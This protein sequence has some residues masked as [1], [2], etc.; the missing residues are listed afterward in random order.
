M[1]RHLLILTI[2]ATAGLQAW[3]TLYNNFAVDVVGISGLQTGIVQSL[4]EVPGFLSLLVVYLLLIFKEH[5]LSAVS[6]ILLGAGVALTGFLPSFSGLILTTLLMSTGFHYFETTNRSL[7]LQYFSHKQAPH[8]LSD[9]KKFGALANIVV[10][11]FFWFY[12][13]IFAIQNC[14]FVSGLFVILAGLLA[15]TKDPVDES[16]PPQHKKMIFRKKYWLFYLLNI[17]SGAR[18]QIFI[19][20]AVFLMVKKYNFHVSEI[21]LLFMINNVITFFLLPYIASAINRFG[22][23]KILTLEYLGMIAVFLGYAYANST[24][25]V[26]LLYLLD[27]IFFNFALAINTYFQKTADPQDIAPSMA[28]G[29]TVNHIAAVI[30]PVVGGALWMFNWQ[31]PFIL[32]ALLSICSLLLVQF[33][34]LPEKITAQ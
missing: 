4:R 22:E 5:T 17:F 27:H 33:I 11:A 20:F 9:L 29:F 16:L 31:I 12:A 13:K 28:I 1:Y 7:A 34:K 23:R 3:R 24:W 32:G 26:S 14:F 19:V 21:S 10:G 18:R 8:V 25:L 2:A 30:I 6:V 15:L